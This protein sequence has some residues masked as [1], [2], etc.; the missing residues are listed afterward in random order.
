MD[1]FYLN[2]D[3]ENEYDE[4]TALFKYYKQKVSKPNFN[5]VIDFK[6]NAD[7]FAK[8]LLSVPGDKRNLGLKDVST[9]ESYQLDN[10]PGF[11][12]IPDPF[13]AEGKNKWSRQCVEDYPCDQNETNIGFLSETP[14]K[15]SNEILQSTPKN[16]LSR[17]SK[18]LKVLKTTPVWKLRWATLGLRYNWNTKEY[19]QSGCSTFPAEVNDLSCVIA[20]AIGWKNYKAEVA[21]V[22]YY[23]VGTNICP[24]TDH[25]EKDLSCPLV[26]VSFG[27]PAIFLLGG[28]TKDTKP[29]AIMVRSGDVIVMSGP[30]RLAYHA[31]PRII[32]DDVDCGSAD[33]LDVYLNHTRINLNV[34]Q[35]QT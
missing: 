4:F 23:H 17:Y 10:C 6:R 19:F 28:Q 8:T 5:E 14:W 34:R 2:E 29:S 15:I 30:S 32:D 18:Q 26:S 11:H 3:S 12:F 25:S 27:L 22:N 9:W 16:H 13:T 1:S 20:S 7:R 24:H 21:I 33:P 31:V 35:F